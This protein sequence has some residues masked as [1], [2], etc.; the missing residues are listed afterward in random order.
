MAAL[1]W[2]RVTTVYYGAEIADAESGGFN[3]LRLPAA[4]LLRAGGSRVKLVPGLLSD[5]CRSL[6]DEWRRSP[7]RRP[8]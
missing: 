3:E 1:H 4:E 5:E 6:F 2:A 7:G 8:Y